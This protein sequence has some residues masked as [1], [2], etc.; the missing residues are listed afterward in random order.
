MSGGPSISTDH[1]GPSV[2]TDHIGLSVGDLEGISA[3][4][5]AVFGLRPHGVH[6]VA[7]GAA[8]TLLLTGDGGLCLELTQLAGSEPA[9]HSSVFEGARTQGWFHW[10]LRVPDLVAALAAVTAAGGSVVTEPAP[11]QSRPGIR[12]AYITDPEGNLVELTQAAPAGLGG[13][14]ARGGATATRGTR[15]QRPRRRI[16]AL[17]F[18]VFGTVVDLRGSVRDAARTYLGAVGRDQDDAGRLTEAWLTTLNAS[19]GQARAE[20]SA[21]SG[22]DELVR[23]SLLEA[24][25]QVGV[26][27]DDSAALDEPAATMGHLRPWPDAASAIARLARERC[28]VALSHA[29][30]AALTELSAASGIRWHCVLSSELVSSYKPDPRVYAF[31]LETLRLAPSETLMVAAHTWDLEAAARAGMATALVGREGEDPVDA[32]GDFDIRARELADLAERLGAR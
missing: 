22:H 21:W 15:P 16:A 30:T 12:F 23:R 5:Q 20:R 14:P 1:S 17:L 31:A 7:G 26:V 19:L 18:D 11:A 24:V 8:R 4:Y 28:V 6:E 29:S 25:E 32:P 3:F 9:R 10:S 27:D 2:S 13:E